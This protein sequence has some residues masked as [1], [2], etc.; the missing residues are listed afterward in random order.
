MSRGCKSGSAGMS[1]RSAEHSLLPSLSLL[2]ECS[3]KWS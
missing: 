1:S 3:L 2:L